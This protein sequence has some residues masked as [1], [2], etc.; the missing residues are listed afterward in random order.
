[1]FA[2]HFIDSLDFARKG[3]EIRGEAPLAEMHRLQD[4]LAAPEGAISYVVRGLQDR[5]GKPMLEVSL[6]GVCQLQCQRCLNSLTYPIQQLSH[7]LLVEESELDEFSS[8]EDEHDYIPV[9]KRL[10]VLALIEDEILLNLPFAPVHPAGECR[11]AVASSEQSEK[12]PFA[13]L[14]GLKKK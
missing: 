11:V 13:V 8:D 4:K 2:R 9:D 14:A 1:M 10:D 3:S 12:S 6:T 5:N 7:L